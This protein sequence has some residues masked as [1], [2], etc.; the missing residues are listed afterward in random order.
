L[1]NDIGTLR[2]D[3]ERKFQEVTTTIGGVIDSLNE[4]IDAHVVATRKMTGYPKKRMLE[5]DAYL[6]ILRSIGQRQ[7]IV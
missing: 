6:M 4:R 2:N 1:S 5:R 7:K 3:T